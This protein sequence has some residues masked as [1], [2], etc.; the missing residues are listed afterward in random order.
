MPRTRSPGAARAGTSARNS[1]PGAR[2]SLWSPPHPGREGPRGARPFPATDERAVHRGTMR[3]IRENAFLIHSPRATCSPAPLPAARPASQSLGTESPGL[4]RDPRNLHLPLN[5]C[6]QRRSWLSNTREWH[7]QS[8]K[9]LKPKAG[10][11]RLRPSLVG[12]PSP[13]PPRGY[14]L[15]RSRAEDPRVGSPSRRRTRMRT[16]T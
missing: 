5:C 7:P 12:S 1:W 13:T 8:P 10:M 6:I 9:S 4:R 15:S 11:R 3:E 16:S 2:F 14:T